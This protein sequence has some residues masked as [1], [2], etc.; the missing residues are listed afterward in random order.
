MAESLLDTLGRG[1]TDPVLSQINSLLGAASGA[2]KAG[3]NAQKQAYLNPIFSKAQTDALIG[4]IGTTNMDF[5]LGGAGAL[6]GALGNVGGVFADIMAQMS[7]NQEAYARRQAGNIVSQ[8]GGTGFAS[9]FRT[10]AA[11]ARGGDQS[12]QAGLLLDELNRQ[13][14]LRFESSF[15]GQDSILGALGLAMQEQQTRLAGPDTSQ[16]GNLQQVGAAQQMLPG[17]LAAQDLRNDQLRQQMTILGP[18][19][20]LA[21]GI[22]GFNPTNSPF[23]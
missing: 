14:D 11:L 9:Q 23:K 15:R 8:T 22:M 12:A 7:A 4:Q 16:I 17:Q 10:D 20:Q 6:D 1:G 18:A 19:E 13:R 21:K 2:A 5:S 3:F